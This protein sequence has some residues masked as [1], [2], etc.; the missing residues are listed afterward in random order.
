MNKIKIIILV[1]I[2]LAILLGLFYLIPSKSPTK[3]NVFV[4]ILDNQNFEKH[5]N[6]VVEKVTEELMHN[7]P[8]EID[9]SILTVSNE[10]KHKMTI[11]MKPGE[12]ELNWKS[13]VKRTLEKLLKDT[14][15]TNI[16]NQSTNDLFLQ[17]LQLMKDNGESEENYYILTGAFPECYNDIYSKTL[18][19]NINNSLKGF[20]TKSKIIWSILDTREN[21]E[22]ILKSL[23]LLNSFPL[24]DRRI[25]FEKSRECV[26]NS[27]QQV[28]GVFFDK[29]N[30]VNSKDFSIYLE[31]NF[32]DNVSL[33]I[34]NDGIYNNK[35][36]NFS[37]QD[38][39]N[40][41]NYNIL[42]SLDKGRWSSIGYLLK[43]ATNKFVQLPDSI[44]KTLFIIGNLPLESKGNQL[45]LET[46]KLLQN[47]KNL[48]VIIYHPSDFR[49][50]ETDKVFVEGLKYYKI[51]FKNS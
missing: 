35:V 41:S 3:I 4:T 13:E 25:I 22:S 27:S 30:I 33:T 31:N 11:N 44:D 32:G 50:N 21:E 7:N 51:K 12:S 2:L 24:I 29:F 5:T 9:L 8:I 18:M 37:K 39:I 23:T 15:I 28:F 36:L 49:E 42:T 14:T 1:S 16:S 38:T 43:Q 6:K 17:T 10:N 45:D 34:W 48:N 46:W 26:E 19:D 20:Q 47:I 40:K